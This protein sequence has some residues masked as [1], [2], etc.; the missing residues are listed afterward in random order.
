MAERPE[1][2]R[3]D[4]VNLIVLSLGQGLMVGVAI[5]LI[6]IAMPVVEAAIV[7][8]GCVAFWVLGVLRIRQ[9]ILRAKLPRPVSNGSKFGDSAS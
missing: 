8:V 2:T 6:W 3:R 4:R 1:M 9:F 7:T 5:A